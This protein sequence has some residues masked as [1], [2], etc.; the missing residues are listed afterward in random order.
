MANFSN[1][2]TG[3]ELAEALVTT[4]MAAGTWI[5]GHECQDRDGNVE[6]RFQRPMSPTNPDYGAWVESRN[7]AAT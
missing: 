5:Q 4:R 1:D 7:T 3:R 6:V 2:D